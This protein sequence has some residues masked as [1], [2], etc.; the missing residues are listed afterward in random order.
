MLLYFHNLLSQFASK[1]L[2]FV[3]DHAKTH[4]KIQALAFIV[5]II[6]GLLIVAGLLFSSTIAWTIG[7]T[8]YV[9]PAFWDRIELFLV[10]LE[11]E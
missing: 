4:A 5:N 8:L 7:I 3:D 9:I 6:G 2:R 1:V 10:T 11:N